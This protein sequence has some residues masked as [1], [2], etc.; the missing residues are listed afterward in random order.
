LA[1]TA[2]SRAWA[3]LQLAQ[4]FFMGLRLY[5]AGLHL[6]LFEFR[7]VHG[8]GFSRWAAGALFLSASKASPSHLCSLV[9]SAPIF[10]QKRKKKEDAAALP[11]L[12]LTN[13][14][15]CILCQHSMPRRDLYASPSSSS[16]FGFLN[17]L[18]SVYLYGSYTG[19]PSVHI[20]SSIARC[21]AQNKQHRAPPGQIYRRHRDRVA[22][23]C[24]APKT[25]TPICIALAN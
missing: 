23:A 18:L 2:C 16:L 9:T 7:N 3:S 14:Q 1:G 11:H 12:P 4:F 8:P 19:H 20:F 24:H 17:E 22:L 13:K 6:L 10:S 21:Q 25:Y 5:D 15:I